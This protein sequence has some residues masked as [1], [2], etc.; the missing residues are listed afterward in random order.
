MSKLFIVLIMFLGFQSYAVEGDFKGSQRVRVSA[1]GNAEGLSE[2]LTGNVMSLSHINMRSYVAGK[3]KPSESL[4]AKF[5][6]Y[7]H[8]DENGE[9]VLTPIGYGDWMFSDEMMLRAGRSTYKIGKGE[10][11]GK[12]KYENFPVYFEGL[13]FTFLSE[14][15]GLDLAVVQATSPFEDFVLS[16]NDYGIASLDVKSLPQFV[17]HLNVHG[18]FDIDDVVNN[19]RFGATLAGKRVA[20][21]FGYK[22]TV[23]LDMTGGNEAN[24][25]SL[26]I[27]AKIGYVYEW[28]DQKFK[29][30]VGGHMDGANYDAFL[31]DRHK[32]AGA[33]DIVNW[34]GGLQYINAGIAYWLNPEWSVGLKG[35]YFNEIGMIGDVANTNVMDEFNA[36]NGSIEVDA[37]VKGEFSSSVYGKLWLASLRNSNDEYSTKVEAQLKMKF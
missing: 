1:Q 5:G 23:A 9:A 36:D 11:I 2:A 18:I 37:Y 32:Y 30:Y 28:N 27:D 33:I 16:D 26:L 17:D 7:L 15:V 31:Y 13:F 19:T 4:E 29:I 21:G 6:S 35:Y 10:V 25:D 14:A 34:G 8:F 22:A 3:F 24:M 12:N 20:G